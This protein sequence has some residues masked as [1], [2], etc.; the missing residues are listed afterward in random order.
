MF[1]MLLQHFRNFMADGMVEDSLMWN[2]LVF[3]PG[4]LLY[5]VYSSKENAQR[6]EVATFSMYF[7][8]HLISLHGLIEISNIID[9]GRGIVPDQDLHQAL[10]VQS[11]MVKETEKKGITGGGLNPLNPLRDLRDQ[12]RETPQKRNKINHH[13]TI[14]LK[15]RGVKHHIDT[16]ALRTAAAAEVTIGAETTSERGVSAQ[17][18]DL[19]HDQGLDGISADLVI[20][21]LLMVI[22]YIF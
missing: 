19:D 21:L 11:T 15:R 13:P 6:V 3:P 4:N 14:T 7:A 18:R 22:N 16:T 12:K 5:V 17:D 2:L 8:I 20:F 1:D 10:S 9:K